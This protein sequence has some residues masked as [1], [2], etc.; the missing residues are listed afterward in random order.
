MVAVRADRGSRLAAFEILVRIRDTDI[1]VSN[2][3][4][5]K[6]GFIVS[7]RFWCLRLFDEALI[8]GKIG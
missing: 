1:L 4:I 5:E 8:W 3:A 2:V 7:V 6:M